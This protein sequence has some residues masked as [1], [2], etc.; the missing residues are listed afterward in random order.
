MTA[1]EIKTFRSL[2][3]NRFDQVRPVR[4]TDGMGG[5]TVTWQTVA[6]FMGRLRPLTPNEM[7]TAMRMDEAFTHILYAEPRV[8]EKDDQLS[9][10][11]ERYRV[12]A[13]QEPSYA[14]F[15]MQLYLKREEG[16]Q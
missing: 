8:F 1:L 14:N 13:S 2:L 5:F 12:I 4:T 6:T 7:E 3:N 9:F 10:R 11:G 16:G 15:H